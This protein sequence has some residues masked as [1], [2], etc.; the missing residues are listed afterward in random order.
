[1]GDNYSRGLFLF[2][3]EFCLR[4]VQGF[5]L[6]YG[7]N[8]ADSSSPGK[9]CVGIQGPNDVIWT[10]RLEIDGNAT[11][12]CNLVGTKPMDWIECDQWSKP[13]PS[14]KSVVIR[15]RLLEI[16]TIIDCESP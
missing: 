14:A 7:P 3:K 15:V 2:S 11:E 12:V 5:K 1:M 9:A 8:G 16:A 6:A 10:V 4:V 13:S